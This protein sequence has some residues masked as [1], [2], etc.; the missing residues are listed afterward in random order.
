M[1]PATPQLPERRL[2]VCKRDPCRDDAWS[3]AAGR[4]DRLPVARQAAGADPTLATIPRLAEA[5]DR[6]P[7]V[8][9][10]QQVPR[11]EGRTAEVIDVDR[12]NAGL[13]IS[14]DQN[15]GHADPSEHFEAA[16]PRQ[17]EADETV[18]GR[19]A[20][21]GLEGAVQGGDQQQ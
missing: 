16:I 4:T 6:N 15:A 9:K 3:G 14:V 10:L 17:A 20:D 5:D 11:G 13:G 18:N 8:T 19:S 2:A 1:I 7:L 21:G 12:G